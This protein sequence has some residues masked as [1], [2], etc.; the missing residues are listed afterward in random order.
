MRWGAPTRPEV[1]VS[2]LL[3]DS[4][5]AVKFRDRILSELHP[6]EL[7]LYASDAQVMEPTGGTDFN[8]Y[9]GSVI[10]T[11]ERLLVAEGKMMG[12]VAFQSLPWS[13][14]EKSGRLNDGKVGI[15]ESISS[16]SRWPLWEISIW[17]GKSYK[18]PLDKKRLGLLSLSIQEAQ[19]AVAASNEADVDSAYDELKRRRGV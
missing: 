12:R 8:L 11:K 9:I 13:D 17:E 10:V 6:G 19:E 3:N 1:D 15:R 4:P 5:T 16:T 14:V 7:V 2:D 18:T